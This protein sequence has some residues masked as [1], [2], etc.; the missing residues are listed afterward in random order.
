MPQNPTGL[1]FITRALYSRN[2]RLFFAGQGVSLVG[3]WMQRIAIGWLV[4]RLTHSVFL[5]G[6]IGFASQI[7]V[8]LLS[9]LAGVLADRWNRRPLL[10]ITQAL[11]MLQAFAMAVL[12]LT[13]GIA[14]WHIILLSILLGIINAF[15]TP[16]RQSFVV[17]MIEKREDLGNAIA[18]NSSMFNGAR[19]LGP[20]IAGLL[21][22]A[23]GEGICFL[24][25]G[26]SYIAVIF[27]LMEMKI[28]WKKP[29]TAKTHILRE[30]KEGFV[31]SF[32]FVPIRSILILLG[33]VSLVAMP[34]TVLM[35][36]FAKDILHGGPSTLGFLMGATGVGALAGAFYLASR[37]NT[38]QL[39][40]I[41]IFSTSIFGAGLITFSMSRTFWLCLPLMSLTGFGM[42]AQMASCNTVLQTIADDAKRGRVMSFY[43]MAFLGTAPFGSF[44]AGSLASKIGTPHTLFLGGVCCTLASLVFARRLPILKKAIGQA[45]FG[46]DVISE[47]TVGI[48]KATELTTPP[49][50]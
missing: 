19:L 22:A 9:P 28:V 29:P 31:Y 16:V 3:T 48:Q 2:Y 50:D 20:S 6:T 8:L 38:E 41:I 46:K 12:V 32:G 13:E 45:G 18:L 5:L 27:A 23:V 10:I 25:N 43:T 7:P 44:L 1:K 49:K 36:V 24:L 39:V 26:I 35:P 34:Y 21:I 11:S 17:E 30:L 15:D 33:L 42:I 4:Y 40:T 47:V 37:K 14:V